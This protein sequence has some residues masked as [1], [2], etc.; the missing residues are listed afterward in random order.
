M[1]DDPQRPISE[2]FINLKSFDELV[3]A[4]VSADAFISATQTTEEHIGTYKFVQVITVS[5]LSR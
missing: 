3:E 5:R 1:S 2:P 4:V